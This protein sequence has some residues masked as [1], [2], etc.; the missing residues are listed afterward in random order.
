MNKRKIALVVALCVV[1][2]G[3]VIS[4]AQPGDESDPVVTLSYIKDTVIPTIYDYIDDKLSGKT[5]NGGEAEKFSV[6]ELAEGRKIICDSGCEIIL[7]AGEA[8][9]IAT[10]KGGLADTTMG[11]DLAD[12]TAVP[13]NHL[14]IVPVADGRGVEAVKD[15]ILMV[16][17]K[18]S[19]K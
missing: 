8:E 17:G 13:G 14:L 19:V 2:A 1:M 6:L 7:R 10:E 15:C 4:Y 3:V 5:D 12:G 16:K 11:A 9:I 18:Y